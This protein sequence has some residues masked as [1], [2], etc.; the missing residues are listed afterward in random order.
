M[1]SM[2]ITLAALLIIGT[3]FSKAQKT[4]DKLPT[5]PQ[6]GKCYV[7]CVT[8]NVFET[9]EQQILVTPAYKTI[10]IM[11]AE[12]KTVTYT[13]TERPAYKKYVFIP[14]VFRTEYEEVRTGE[15]HNKL[16]VVPAAL[17][18]S[19]ERLEVAP[20]F[21]RWEYGE[22]A[23]GCKSADPFACR[24]ICWKEYPAKYQTFATKVLDKDAYT[25]SV[26]V[27]GKITKLKKQVLVTDGYAK[28]IMVP[29]VTKNYTRRELVRDE[30]I[31]EV[32]IPAVYKTIKVKVLKE[33]GGITVWEEVDCGLT[34]NNVLP[35]YYKL[36]SAVLT[37]PSKRTIDNTLLKLLNAKP[38]VRVEISSHTDARG[39]SSSNL[40]LSQR[41]AQSVVNYL[42]SKG[43]S[44]SRMVPS[45]FGETRLKNRCADGVK[46]SE[47]EHQ[48]NR[49]TEFRIL[50]Y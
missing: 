45:G 15:G 12:Y 5:N 25:T 10:R 49:R 38:N 6:P 46:C 35:V 21:G 31:S 43:I 30:T 20:I 33:K 22:K 32:T 11:P 8:P 28:E 9:V 44:K 24:T 13:I 2:K 18:S 16:R 27:E 39:T 19:S 3:F 17:K 1:R 4:F 50:S 29:A 26:P 48:Q 7:K 37:Q 36:G 14:A 42:S 47:R 23:P 34:Q 40:D 41:R